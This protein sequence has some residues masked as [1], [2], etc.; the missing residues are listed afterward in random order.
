MKP[1]AKV[2]KNARKSPNSMK[3]I[4]RALVQF[5]SW[6]ITMTHF[7]QK[8]LSCNKLCAIIV[9]G[10]QHKLCLPLTFVTHSTQVFRITEG[11]RSLLAEKEGRTVDVRIML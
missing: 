7:L 11:L 3:S 6:S 5:G 4:V 1:M 2:Y 9:V 8:L 10:R